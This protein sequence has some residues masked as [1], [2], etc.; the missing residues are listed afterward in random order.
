[1]TGATSAPQHLHASLEIAR[2]PCLSKVPE[3][4]SSEAQS[5]GQVD[6]GDC[7]GKAGSPIYEFRLKDLGCRAR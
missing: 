1:M 3:F 2:K 5:E 4:C 7:R 6:P